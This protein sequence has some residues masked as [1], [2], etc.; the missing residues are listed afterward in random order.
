MI[1]ITIFKSTS[2]AKQQTYESFLERERRGEEKLK[3]LKEINKKSSWVGSS[4]SQ[5]QRIEFEP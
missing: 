2:E 1:I 3:D 4:L 5:T